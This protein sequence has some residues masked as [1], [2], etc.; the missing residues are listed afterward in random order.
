[1]YKDRLK[2]VQKEKNDEPRFVTLEEINEHEKP[3]EQNEA[4]P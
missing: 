4:P 1:M 3:K 2:V